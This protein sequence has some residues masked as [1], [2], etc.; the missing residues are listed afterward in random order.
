MKNSD[1]DSEME[2]LKTRLTHIDTRSENFKFER[3]VKTVYKPELNNSD[4]PFKPYL[5]VQYSGEWHYCS[6]YNDSIN[7]E[8]KLQHT[9]S[10]Y[11]PHYVNDIQYSTNCKCE[12]VSFEQN[13]LYNF[14]VYF[15]EII[16]ENFYV[17][18]GKVLRIEHGYAFLKECGL[19]WASLHLL[20]TDL[21]KDTSIFEKF[22]CKYKN[23]SL[24]IDGKKIAHVMR[25][26]D[27]RPYSYGSMNF[28]GYAIFFDCTFDLLVTEKKLNALF[29][30]K[31]EELIKSLFKEQDISY[32]CKYSNFY[33]SFPNGLNYFLDYKICTK[34]D[35]I[36]VQEK[37]NWYE[38]KQETITTPSGISVKLKTEEEVYQLWLNSMMFQH[39]HPKNET[40][41]EHNN[42]LITMA[43]CKTFGDFT[44]EDINFIAGHLDEKRYP[45][46]TPYLK[47]PENER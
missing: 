34:Q 6:N 1:F 43:I 40:S 17:P 9:A 18:K 14:R 24:Y 44:P 22:G 41:R 37:H 26:R 27:S 2:M 23:R 12:W 4:K 15:K 28:R 21:Q 33:L 39:Y 30:N 13:N 11:A 16:Q 46:V 38:C 36:K 35:V 32:T 20:A 29:N 5:E 7:L 47:M 8:R 45:I 3:F 25:Y 42:H 10:A 19:E 31:H